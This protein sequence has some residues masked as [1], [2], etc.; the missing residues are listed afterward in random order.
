M[1]VGFVCFETGKL[2]S[3]NKSL[4]LLKIHF[5]FHLEV[6][7]SHNKLFISVYKFIQFDAEFPIKR[8]KI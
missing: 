4:N 8:G 5:M 7:S 1:G 2:S 6:N 3:L